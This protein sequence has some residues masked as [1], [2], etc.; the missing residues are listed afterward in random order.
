[1]TSPQAV[2]PVLPLTKTL[3][4]ATQAELA[5]ALTAAAASGTPIYPLGGGTALEFGL[6]ARRE[7]QGLSLAALN[8]VVDYPARD[9]TI[10]LEAGV[11]LAEL[12]AVLAREGQRLPVDAPHAARATIGGAIAT[13]ASGPRRY[14]N[15]TLRDYVIG[16]SAVDGTGVLFKAGG[17]VVKNVAG[18]DLCKLLTGSLGTLAVITQVTLKVKPIPAASAFVAIDLPTN[19]QLT[20]NLLAGLVTSAA[21]PC[22]IELLGGSAWASDPALGPAKGDVQRLVVGLEGTI[23]EVDWMLN[24]LEREWRETPACREAGEPRLVRVTGEAVAPLWSRLTEFPAGEA[25][26]VLE[27]GVPPSGVTSLMAEFRLA[28]PA[29]SLQAHAGDGVIIARFS[30]FAADDVSKLL[31]GRLQVAAARLGGHVVVRSARGDF[32]WTRRAWWGMPGDELAVMQSVKTQLDP[33]GI[34]NPDR[35]VY[36]G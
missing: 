8:R 26:I 35:F 17:R 10:T 33:R 36:P 6:P 25:P 4:P 29:C 2:A 3:T 5:A 15:G 19:S 12:A 1:V 30:R 9:M 34:L 27:A 21:T 11:T 24:T 22:A 14:G 32:G 31:V 18:Y 23:E 7:G 20:E 13:N 16:I 28:D